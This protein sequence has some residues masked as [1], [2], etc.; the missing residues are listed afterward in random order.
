MAN[1]TTILTSSSNPG[2]ERED[3]MLR[4]FLNIEINCVADQLMVGG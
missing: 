3:Q 1:I 4:K 2:R